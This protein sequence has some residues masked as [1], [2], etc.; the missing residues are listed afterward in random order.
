MAYSL[1][2]QIY[3]ALYGAWKKAEDD[4]KYGDWATDRMREME[5]L[6]TGIQLADENLGRRTARFVSD[7]HLKRLDAIRS[8]R[9]PHHLFHSWQSRP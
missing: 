2:D 9:D 7:A 1:E 4:G 8:A 5:E 3:L 6:S